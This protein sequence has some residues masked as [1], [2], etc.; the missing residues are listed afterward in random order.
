MD[1]SF[2]MQRIEAAMDRQ[3]Q[4]TEALAIAIEAMTVT[5]QQIL[6]ALITVVME[7]DDPD[8]QPMRDMDGKP[9]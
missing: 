1:Y 8:S 5:N 6:E 3:A 7:N 9:V 2:E 4:A